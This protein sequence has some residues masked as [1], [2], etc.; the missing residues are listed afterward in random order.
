MNESKKSE[1]STTMDYLVPNIP[2]D[3]TFNEY[4]NWYDS[5]TEQE[6]VSVDNFQDTHQK[7]V[8]G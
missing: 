5:L 8:G 6:R 3:M 7:R 1:P 4:N 2:E